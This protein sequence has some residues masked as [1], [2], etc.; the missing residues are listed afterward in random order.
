MSDYLLDLSTIH[1]HPKIR[2]DGKLYEMLTGDDLGIRDIAEFQAIAK[3]AEKLQDGDLSPDEAG[4]I[5]IMIDGMI[6][7]ITVGLPD[8][9]REKLT[10]FQKIKIIEVFSDA[11]TEQTGRTATAKKST[12]EKSSP[13]SNDSMAA[14]PRTG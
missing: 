14:T 2:I 3:S 12:G 4:E 10:D 8:N 13:A 9:L 6:R 11:V 7:S 1:E 5:A